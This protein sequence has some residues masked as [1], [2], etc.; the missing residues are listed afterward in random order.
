MSMGR[1]Q[2][3]CTTIENRDI[4]STL[5]QSTNTVHEQDSPSSFRK[6][7]VISDEDAF[8]TRALLLID[9][10]NI[11]SIGLVQRFGFRVSG[12]GLRFSGF[13]GKVQGVGFRCNERVHTRDLQYIFV[14]HVPVPGAPPMVDGVLDSHVS[15][16][17]ARRQQ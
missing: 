12:S 17:L 6:V 2:N 4:F 16:C 13:G 14:K 11:I 1:L 8:E 5:T 10:A 7:V 9:L 15:R 3:E